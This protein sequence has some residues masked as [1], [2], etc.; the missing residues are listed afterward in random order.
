MR[1]CSLVFKDL[2]EA[3]A[4]TKTKTNKAPTSSTCPIVYYYRI[5]LTP[6]WAVKGIYKVA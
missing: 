4:K 2:M 5:L 1:S 3:F 6:R